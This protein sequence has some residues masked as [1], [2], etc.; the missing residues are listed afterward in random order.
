ML[1]LTK[2]GVRLVRKGKTEAEKEVDRII[3]KLTKIK[4]SACGFIDI[5]NVD[6][7]HFCSLMKFFAHKTR[8][9]VDGRMDYVYGWD[10][11]AWIACR[12]REMKRA[13]END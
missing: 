5:N 2:S 4:P 8:P 9:L 1:D 11:E 10:F 6:S 3:V 7:I 13:L 12:A